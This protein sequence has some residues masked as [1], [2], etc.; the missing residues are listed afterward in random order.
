VAFAANVVGTRVT[1]GRSI[2]GTTAGAGDRD[3]PPGPF[4]TVGTP[5][6]LPFFAT[7]QRQIAGTF[8]ADVSVAYTTDELE[9]AGIP[10][11]SDVEAALALGAFVAGACATGSAPCAED[12]DCGVK[13]PCNGA[14]YTLL[15]TT[16]DTAQH[17]ATASVT[18]FSTFAVL[19]PN[20]VA[21]GAVVPRIPGRGSARTDCGAEWEVVNATNS[22]FTSRGAVNWNQTCTDGDPNCDADRTVD[23]TCHF[24][25]AVCLNQLDPNLAACTPGTTSSVHVYP[26]RKPDVLAS[27]DALLGAL[28]GLGGTRTGHGLSDV[29]FSPALGGSACTAF[30]SL[31]VPVA[32][33]QKLRIRAIDPSGRT[34]LDRLRLVCSAG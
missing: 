1:A 10:P 13:G 24:R 4:S 22:P 26:S 15:P 34:D 3:V 31:A 16:I 9:R 17:V 27:N 11:G 20:V 21:G 32:K 5:G 28:E 14:T 25:V 12:G 30:T 2:L 29:S 33:K 23:G 19:H 8:A 18:S 6:I 7:L